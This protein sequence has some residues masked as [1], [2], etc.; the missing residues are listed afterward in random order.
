[1][2]HLLRFLARGVKAHQRQ[3]HTPLRGVSTAP[4]LSRVSASAAEHARHPVSHPAL[5]GLRGRGLIDAL[6]VHRLGRV[7][8]LSSTWTATYAAEAER[9]LR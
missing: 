9:G 4:R 7:V 6:Q 2:I 3:V 8:P 1:M 5:N